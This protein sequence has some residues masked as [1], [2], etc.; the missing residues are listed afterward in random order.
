MNNISLKQPSPYNEDKNHK[1]EYCP[2]KR[3]LFCQE[4][5]CKGCQVYLDWCKSLWE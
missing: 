2:Y 4:G 3:L 5:C 1:G